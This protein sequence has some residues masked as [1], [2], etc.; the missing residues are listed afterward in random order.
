[1][2]VVPGLPLPSL[3]RLGVCCLGVEGGT[4]PH[5][6]MLGALQAAWGHVCCWVDGY[7]HCAPQN[8]DSTSH[9]PF[10]PGFMDSDMSICTMF[11]RF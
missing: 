1:M 8:P 5:V 2:D 4:H 3:C 9:G 10:E 11:H 6:P 7:S